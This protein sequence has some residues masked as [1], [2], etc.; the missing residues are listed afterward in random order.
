MPKWAICLI[1]FLWKQSVFVFNLRPSW[2]ES[3]L[4]LFCQNKDKGTYLKTTHV[5]KHFWNCLDSH[6]SFLKKNWIGNGTNK[7][8]KLW[9]IDD[10]LVNN[11]Y[12]IYAIIIYNTSCSK[13]GVLNWLQML[14]W[15]CKEFRGFE[16]FL[17]VDIELGAHFF[18]KTKNLPLKNVRA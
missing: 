4:N 10:I 12:K 14:E 8:F 9:Q 17:S 18:S 5:E 16:S 11:K 15:A 13:G 3:A 1:S 2:N 7:H 6:T